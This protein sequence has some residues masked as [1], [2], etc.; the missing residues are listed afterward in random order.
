LPK[1]FSFSPLSPQWGERE[2]VR[3]DKKKPLATSIKEAVRG[4]KEIMA[5]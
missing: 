1:V 2:R 3:G 5:P 4:E